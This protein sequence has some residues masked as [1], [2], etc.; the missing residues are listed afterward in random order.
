MLA[1]LG[2]SYKLRREEAVGELHVRAEIAKVRVMWD[3]GL[4]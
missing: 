1:R 4:R 3:G 2:S